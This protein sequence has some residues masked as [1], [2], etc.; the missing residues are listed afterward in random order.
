MSGSKKTY[1]PENYYVKKAESAMS[2]YIANPKDRNSVRHVFGKEEAPNRK[3][4]MEDLKF[5]EFKAQRKAAPKDVKYPLRNTMY[6]P[7]IVT[8]GGLTRETYEPTQEKYADE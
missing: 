6:Q 7:D 4:I 2:T 3:E 8:Y 1:R 5:K